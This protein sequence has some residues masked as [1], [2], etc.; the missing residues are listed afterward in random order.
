MIGGSAAYFHFR[1]KNALNTSSS[2]S[3]VNIK[4]TELGAGNHIAERI[5]ELSELKDKGILTEGEFQAK[6][7]ELLNRL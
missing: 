7:T 5:R 2:G 4:P 6:K 1:R 3:G